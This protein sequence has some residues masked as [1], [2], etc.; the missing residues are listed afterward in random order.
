MALISDLRRLWQPGPGLASARTEAELRGQTEAFCGATSLDSQTGLLIKL[1][2]GIWQQRSE[3]AFQSRLLCWLGV[4]EQDADLRSRFQQTW[5]S[6][7]G[8]LDSVPSWRKR[9]FPPSMRSFERSPTA[10]SNAGCLRRGRRRIRR[11]CS[12]QSFVPRALSSAFCR[13]M[14]L[15]L[16]AWRP[17]SGTPKG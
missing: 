12:P 16:L 5:Q 17:T 4:L 15:C 8:K 2:S 3:R 11:D 13:W 14:R 6:T 10:F 1:F 7:L 9:E